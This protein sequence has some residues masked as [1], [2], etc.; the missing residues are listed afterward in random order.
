VIN[1][2]IQNYHNLIS[3]RK[4]SDILSGSVWVLSAQVASAFFAMIIQIIIARFYGVETL[5]VVSIINSFIMLISIF[6]VLG[7]GTSILRLIPEHIANFSPTSA[8]RIYRKSLCIVI[9]ASLFIAILL[10]LSSDIVARHVFN[11]PHL[12]AY[13]ALAAAF[14]IFKSLMVL[15]TQSTRGLKHIRIYAFLQAFPQGFNL[16]FLLV[17]GIFIKSSDLPVHSLLL[18]F[19]VTGIASWIIVEYSFNIKIH[20]DDNIHPMPT[21]E[22]L[23]ISLPMFLAAS[24]NYL[25]GQTGL[26]MLGV[27]RSESEVGYYTAAVKLATL[28]S[29]VLTGINSM[30]APKF[31]ELFF[32]NQVEELFRV[33]KK[34]TKLIFWTTTPI[35]FLLILLGKKIIAILFGNDFILAYWAMVLLVLGQFV[36]SISGSTGIFMNMTGHQKIYRNIMLLTSFLNIISNLALIPRF[37]LIGAA[38]AGMLSLIFWNMASLIFIKRKY[39]KTIGYFPFYHL[40]TSY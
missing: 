15:N 31:S 3:D 35:L 17:I 1:T 19:F 2:I 11:K 18:S 10:Y 24:M 30:A 4:F 20:P 26:F 37:G 13:L 32:T 40:R 9:L 39:G 21:R 36:H 27:F 7:T 6:T 5:G 16:L 12:S 23:F 34:S 28:T 22:I 25:V 14:V 38:I 33:A 8:F 29:F